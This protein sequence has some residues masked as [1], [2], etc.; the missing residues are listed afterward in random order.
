M[1]Q[2]VTR[3]GRMT[4]RRLLK[5]NSEESRQIVCS[6]KRKQDHRNGRLQQQ[7]SSEGNKMRRVENKIR[8]IE[9]TI[10]GR[11][12][13][14]ASKANHEEKERRNKEPKSTTSLRTMRKRGH[15]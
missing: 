11:G 3:T 9:K 8:M 2:G 14:N 12:K 1:N 13:D 5:K 15:D 10:R 7:S 6:Q 4:T